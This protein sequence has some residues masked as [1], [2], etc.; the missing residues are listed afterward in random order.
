[1]DLLSHRHKSK[2]LSLRVSS[3]QKKRRKSFF[4]HQSGS[5]AWFVFATTILRGWSVLAAGGEESPGRL[6]SMAEEAFVSGRSDD[7]LALWGRV[8]EMEPLNERNY[9]KR[10]RVLSRLKKPIAALADLDNSL[11]LAPEYNEALTSRARLLVSLGRCESGAEDWRLSLQLN[12]N[13]ET[14]ESLRRAEVCAQAIQAAKT[15]QNNRNFRQQIDELNIV[16]ETATLAPAGIFIDRATAYIEL[17]DIYEAIAD[18]GKALK[19]DPDDLKALELRGIAYYRLGD[20]AMAKNHWQQG[21]KLDPEHKGC[22][23]G[24]K[25]VR[26]LVKKD[27]AG[28]A[29]FEQGQ[30]SQALDAY[31]Q[32]LALDPNHK[33][34]AISAHKKIANALLK[35]KKHREAIQSLDTVLEL[36]EN[37][38]DA[39]LVRID[40]L[41]GDEQFDLALRAAKRAREIKDNDRT[42]NAQAKAEAALKQSKSINYYKVLGV[43]RDASSKDIKKAYRDLALKYHPVSFF[44]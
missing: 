27:T 33:A 39:H 11:R 44:F 36:D 21:L 7:A 6:R 2:R 17:G 32:A 37:D 31:K 20:F 42:K 43:R 34:Y 12:H 4:F 23:A 25:L 29:F 3:R 40:A 26:A 41:L 18:L 22:K 10:A 15:A 16:I 19:I 24:Y 1:M 30:F 14:A 5:R 38:L 9:L 8:L 13:S 35:L 28:D